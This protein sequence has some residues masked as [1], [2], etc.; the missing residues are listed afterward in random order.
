MDVKDFAG[1]AAIVTGAAKGIGY[2]IAK[3]LIEHGATVVL[4]DIDVTAVE[5]AVAELNALDRGRALA[6]AGDAGCVDFIYRM[7]DYAAGLDGCR[8]ELVVANAGLTE[9]GDFFT[10]TEKSFQKIV[11][12]N[13]RGTFFL[14]QAAGNKLREQES[15]GRIIL[16]GSNVG[17]RAYHNLAAYGMSKAAIA[18]LAQQLTLDL[19]PLGITVN[20]VAP[21]ATLTARTSVEE[22]DY[23]GIWAELNPNGRVGLPEDVAAAVGFLLSPAASHIT[24]QQLYVDGGWT[25]YAPSPFSAERLRSRDKKA[26]G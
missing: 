10:F 14:A 24:G 6:Y 2:G 17:S 8:F 19:G 7:V 20:C 9:F 22:P 18:M 3:Y 1:K 4:N 12:L 15:G 23:A 21:G 11:D 16:I 25:G 5:E 26:V 13:L